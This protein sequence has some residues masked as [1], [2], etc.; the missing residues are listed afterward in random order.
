MTGEFK[1]PAK[2]AGNG[3]SFAF[4]NESDPARATR[5]GMTC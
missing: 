3:P 4:L 5:A 2:E 1:A